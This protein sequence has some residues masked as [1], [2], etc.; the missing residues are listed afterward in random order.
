MDRGAWQATVHGVTGVGHHLAKLNHHSG[1]KPMSP[2]LQADS[3]PAEPSGKPQT[4]PTP[5]LSPGTSFVEDNFPQTGGRG[6]LGMI[7]AHCIYCVLSCHC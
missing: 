3:L 4:T 5:P 7:Q 1:I 6:G 2:V